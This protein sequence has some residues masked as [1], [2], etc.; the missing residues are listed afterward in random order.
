MKKLDDAEAEKNV[1]HGHGKVTYSDKSVFEGDFSDDK[2]IQGHYLTADKAYSFEGSF[3]VGK[4]QGS[5]TMEFGKYIIKG[6]W[7]NDKLE[8]L[9]NVS[10][11]GDT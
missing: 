11:K 9:A 2:P 3:S 6:T 10:V 4:K 8:G 5:G 1:R 7:T